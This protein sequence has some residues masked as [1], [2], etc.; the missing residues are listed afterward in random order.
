M[1][2]D[3]KG[4]NNIYDHPRTDRRDRD[5]DPPSPCVFQLQKQGPKEERERGFNK[6]LFPEG[7]GQDHSLKVVQEIKA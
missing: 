6:D 1:R 2:M 7:Q 3:Y 4:D 5:A